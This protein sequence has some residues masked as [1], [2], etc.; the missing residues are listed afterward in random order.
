MDFKFAVL[1]QMSDNIK[2]E[3]TIRKDKDS[4]D[5]TFS[6]EIDLKSSL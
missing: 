6:G 2:C 1:R 5:R 4:L 3:D